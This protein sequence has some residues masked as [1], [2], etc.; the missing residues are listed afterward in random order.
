[1]MMNKL[2]IYKNVALLCSEKRNRR[3]EG[4]DA[5]VAV[6]ITRKSRVAVGGAVRKEQLCIYCTKK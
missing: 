2:N 6:V 5:A 3:S 4:D 1:M